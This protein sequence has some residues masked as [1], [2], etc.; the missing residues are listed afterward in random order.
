MNKITLSL[1]LDEINVILGGIGGL[2]YTQVATLIENIR[3]QAMPQVSSQTAI[4][5]AD[6][7]QPAAI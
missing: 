4:P 7:G 3:G 2:P 1:T 6:D 5:E